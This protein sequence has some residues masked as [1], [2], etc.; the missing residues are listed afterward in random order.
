V[1]LL[2][3]G[4]LLQG[5]PEPARWALG[6]VLAMAALWI[7]E[8]V[9]LWVTALLPLILFPALGVAE[10]GTILLEY[11]DP[12]NFLFFGGMLIA[13][14]LEEW[15]LHERMALG[16]VSRVGT[17]PRR[18]VFGFMVATA[19]VSLWMS[20]TAAVVMMFPI[21][22][23]VLHEFR[24]QAGGATPDFRNLA[25]TLMLGIGY[26]ASMGG[27]GSKI[28]TGT[29]LVFVKQ[30]K[31]QLG[32]EVSFVAWFA[33]GLPVVLLAIPLAWL[34]LVR[35][36]APISAEPLPGARAAID[37]RRR[38]FGSMGR[39]EQV[40][41]SAFLGAA[42]LW[43]FRLD[44]DFGWF[45]VPGWARLIPDAWAELAPGLPK[46]LRGL[47]GPQLSEGAVALFIAGLLLI[48]PAGEGRRALSLRAAGRIQ[49]GI[50]TLLGGGFAMAT[51]IARSGL[52]TMLAERLRD[53]QGLAPL[54]TLMLVCL[55]TTA[56]SE[57]ASNTATASILLPV[58]GASAP[59]LGLA[60]ATAMMA[61]TLAA[62][63]GFMLPAGTPP[64]AVVYASGYIPVLRMVRAGLVVDLV[65]AL[66]IALVSY[67]TV[68]WVL[69][70][71]P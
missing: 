27:I 66:V 68:P 44:L 67:W 2:G 61:A 62:S 53:V 20:N 51:G 31:E 71:A 59:H 13:A 47:L 41:L 1:L 17:S 12:V 3:S 37:E 7:S 40:A 14:S 39:G 54:V 11:F 63:F 52:S 57:V 19:F 43:I 45:R 6:T 18:I 69:G 4:W 46:P 58:L 56:L 48:W 65:G 26:A 9:P 50:L 64:N 55:A 35:V 49:W 15:N 32:L 21:G 60:P 34:Y 36:A 23:A 10:F 42:L 25:L 24:R 30:A 38:A 22:M 29:N 16:M 28:G 70:G 8:A 5:L 33:I